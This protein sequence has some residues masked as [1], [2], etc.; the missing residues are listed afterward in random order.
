MRSLL[1]V[2]GLTFICHSLLAQRGGRLGVVYGVAR[3]SMMNADDSKADARVLKLLPTYG[4]QK[5]LEIGYGFRYFGISLQIMRNKYGQAYLRDNY[6]T[7]RTSLTY[8]RPS[9]VLNFNSN[10]A[11]DVRFCGNVG[12]GYGFLNKLSDVA[13]YHNPA[14]GVITTASYSKTEY[15]ITDTNVQKGFLSNSIY[16]NSDVTAFGSLGME[17]RMNPRWLVAFTLR[18]DFGL[19]KLENYD[20]IKKTVLNGTTSTTSD[21]EHWRYSPTKYE[22]DFMYS[23][24]RAASNNFA[25]GM[26]ISIKYVIPSKAIMDYE[27]SGF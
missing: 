10:P 20:A 6:L 26:Y 15:T 8:T 4:A 5:G 24:V 27:M 13:N 22:R 21:Y 25:A 11:K 16:Y 7:A 19:E 2:L 17:V 1:L 3:T 23:G 14:T 12:V 18:G 9:V